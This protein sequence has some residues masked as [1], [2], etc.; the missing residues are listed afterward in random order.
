MGL[1]RPYSV[2]QEPEFSLCHGRTIILANGICLPEQAWVDGFHHRGI[3]DGIRSWASQDL[4]ATLPNR[5]SHLDGVAGVIAI[6][7]CRLPCG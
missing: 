4:A 7:S 2:I 6:H 1:L 5:V 3:Y